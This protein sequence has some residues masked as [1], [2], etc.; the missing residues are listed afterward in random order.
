MLM[1]LKVFSGLR[2][3]ITSRAGLRRTRIR[4]TTR[5]ST[6]SKSLRTSCWWKSSLIILVNLVTLAAAAAARVDVAKRAVVSPPYRPPTGS[7]WTTWWPPCVLLNPT[8]SVASSPTSWSSPVWLTLIWSCISSL[9]TVYLKA[10]VSVAKVSPTGWCIPTSSYGE[11]PFF[12]INWVTF[13]GNEKDSRKLTHLS[14]K[15]LKY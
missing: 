4:W 7:S 2:Y 6:N 9:V 10:F 11:N 5:W 15:C 13:A 12:S 14:H 3:R 1:K 8:S